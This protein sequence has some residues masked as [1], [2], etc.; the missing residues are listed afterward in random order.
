MTLKPAA[1][2]GTSQIEL[3][4]SAASGLLDQ[5]YESA[6]PAEVTQLFFASRRTPFF[7][8]TAVLIGAQN[9]LREPLSEKASVVRCSPRA[10]ASRVSRGP[11]ASM[12]A[13]PQ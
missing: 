10:I 11:N 1:F 7:T 4:P 6:C 2:A 3:T 13:A 5:T 8:L 12:T 9:W